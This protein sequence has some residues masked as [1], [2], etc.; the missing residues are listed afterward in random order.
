MWRH[1]LKRACEV[2]TGIAV[3]TSPGYSETAVSSSAHPLYRNRVY[4]FSVA[5]PPGVTYTRTQP[6]NPDHGLGITLKDQAKLWVDASSTESSSTGEEAEKQTV[7]CRVE[8]KKPAKLGRLS[9]VLVRFSCDATRYDPAYSEQLILSVDQ[10]KDRAPTCF[11]IGVR[12]DGGRTTP[13]EDELFRK[14]VAGFSISN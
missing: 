10:G 12:R 2:I 13:Q 3:L 1:V 9:A 14:L 11:Q 7:G 4:G 6:P 5:I 8:E